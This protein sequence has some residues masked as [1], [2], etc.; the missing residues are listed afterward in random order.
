MRRASSTAVIGLAS[1]LL[2]N[3]NEKMHVL[4]C[5]Q[6]ATRNIDGVSLTAQGAGPA[7][8]PLEKSLPELEP[9]VEGIFR[10]GK[11]EGRSNF[12]T[13]P[14]TGRSVYLRFAD[15]CDWCFNSEAARGAGRVAATGHSLYLREFMIAYLPKS[16]KHSVKTHK[17]VNCGILSFDLVDCGGGDYAVDPHSLLTV[18]GGFEGLKHPDFELKNR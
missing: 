14:F 1:R 17:L 6:E 10:A 11:F 7:A 13:K 5:L 18:Y 4:S 3:K 8:S 12:G 16:F 15:F 2:R 9:V